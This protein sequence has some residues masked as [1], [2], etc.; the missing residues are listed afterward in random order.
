MWYGDEKSV[1]QFAAEV[2]G[3]SVDRLAAALAAVREHDWETT[4]W[5]FDREMEADENGEE[6]V[7]D[8]DYYKEYS[9]FSDD[10]ADQLVDEFK[11]TNDD[12]TL[13]SI[14]SCVK[15]QQIAEAVK[16]KEKSQMLIYAC[17]RL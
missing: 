12:F 5:I 14:I 11:T 8:D 15:W 6:L 9:D 7:E 17:F 4:Q 3:M 2:D 10:M 13:I 16:D 1:E